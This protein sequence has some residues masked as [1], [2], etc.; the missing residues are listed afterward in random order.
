M[1]SAPDPVSIKEATGVFHNM[2]LA[3]N[4]FNAKTRKTADTKETENRAEHKVDAQHSYPPT[5][6][7]ENVT[8]QCICKP[9]FCGGASVTGSGHV[10][11]GEPCQDYH[12]FAY[13]QSGNLVMC[14]ADGVGSA[15]RSDEGARMACAIAINTICEMLEAD[16]GWFPEDDQLFINEAFKHSQS[17]LN[18]F[19]DR[20][21]AELN[22]FATTLI[23]V[24]LRPSRIT[25]GMIGDGQVVFQDSEGEY[26]CL[27]SIQKYQYGNL[28]M[29]ITSAN[30]ENE[31]QIRQ[32]EIAMESVFVLTDGLLSMSCDLHLMTPH[33]PFFDNF[34]QLM[35]KVESSKEACIQ[36]EMFLSHPFFDEETEDDKSIIVA[37]KNKKT[38]QAEG[39]DL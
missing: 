38:C 4:I 10:L 19:A 11:S 2:T 3:H 30:L 36:L 35:G 17:Y 34:L 29:P 21:K 37:Q 26:A 15:S 6:E 7:I 31:L 24:I 13:T 32:V 14:M 20:N 8:P 5:D 12:Q 1:C 9:F 25:A 18:D 28:M 16:Y 23:V 33:R 27:F 22:E 39:A